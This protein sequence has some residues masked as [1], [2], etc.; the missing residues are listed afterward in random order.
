MAV[1]RRDELAARDGVD[2]ARLAKHGAG[3]AL[4]TA[5][6]LAG[7][8]LVLAMSVHFR[9]RWD[10]TRQSANSLSPKSIAAVDTLQHPV[11]VW[12]L[13]KERDP[14][15]E[16]YW[17]LLQLYKRRS[18]N[19][20]V[21]F[22]DPNQ[23]P[24]IV[25]DLG[26]SEQDQSALKDGV[27][28]VR[29]ADRRVVFRGRTEEEVTNAILEVGSD[30]R[31]VVGFIR[32]VGERDSESTA[33]AGLSRAVEALHGEYYDL[34]N[35]RLDSGIP[36]EVTVLIA[37]GPQA[38]L[39]PDQAARLSAWLEAGG[40]LLVLLDPDHDPGLADALE[41]WGLRSTWVKVVDRQ[42]NL[43]S[44]P[45]LPVL[46]DFSQH[47]IVKGFSRSLPI[48]LPLA[49]AV[50]EFEP[51]DPAVFHQ[52]LAKTS[53]YSEGLDRDGGRVA[54][55]FALAAAAWKD[56]E[57][58]GQKIGETRIVLV[59]DVLF[60]TNAYLSEQANRDFFLNTVGWL[61]RARGLV[62]IRE[63]RLAGQKLS[64][65]V[66]DFALLRL[67]VFAPALAMIAAGVVVF[68]RRRGL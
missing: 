26:L 56:L 50:E 1:T 18:G 40:R 19:V 8:G 36:E 59:G 66:R 41:R 15:R 54:G 68:W 35:V 38:P 21:Q 53:A 13:F 28:V 51:K 61:S 39:P 34:E 67:C 48:A 20:A 10:L 23:R 11:E 43:R 4:F 24:A 16:S 55:P 63:N 22:V 62:A 30:A 3:S 2:V 49:V 14:K 42:Q 9:A 57:Q 5:L 64:L 46:T 6:V 47:P 12:A 52:T 27:T 32:G 33:D 65:T 7:L 25:R 37:A 31:R 60:A 17:D 58:N 44:Q 29:R 45:E